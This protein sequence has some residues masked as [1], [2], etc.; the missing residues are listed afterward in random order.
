MSGGRL[1]GAARTSAPA[2]ASGTGL[3]LARSATCRRAVC[4]LSLTRRSSFP[5]GFG[6]P[7]TSSP[8]K[9]FVSCVTSAARSQACSSPA[10]SSS[11]RVLL[12]S[13][14]RR[15][16]LPRWSVRQEGHRP[17]KPLQTR[18]CSLRTGGRACEQPMAKQMRWP[19]LPDMA[20]RGFRVSSRLMP[21]RAMQPAFRTPCM[22]N[23]DAKPSLS[24]CSMWCAM[25]PCP[26]RR[27][28]MA[29]SRSILLLPSL[30]RRA[31]PGPSRRR[32]AWLDS[33]R[34]ISRLFL[35]LCRCLRAITDQPPVMRSRLALCLSRLGPWRRGATALRWPRSPSPRW[36]MGSEVLR[37]LPRPGGF[38]SCISYQGL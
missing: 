28:L 13:R 30:A 29:V 38:L 8:R 32:P 36:R 25:G 27:R 23:A 37:L 2:C 33:S 31:C 18:P 22:L 12:S 10:P 16:L 1:A 26:R 6:C 11:P 5:P 20:C 4:G 7:G 9:S 34:E 3:C 35:H 21:C 17:A 15:C 19:R 14:P 24:S